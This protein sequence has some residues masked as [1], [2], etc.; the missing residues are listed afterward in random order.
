MHNP[1]NIFIKHILVITSIFILCF[2]LHS[3]HLLAD[4]VNKE[5][6]KKSILSI[7]ELTNKN[8]WNKVQKILKAENSIEL[9]DL[10]NWIKISSKNN[11]KN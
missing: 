4:N 3:K 10:A 11:L 9:N 5:I 6:N 2:I 8:K 7:I 1:A